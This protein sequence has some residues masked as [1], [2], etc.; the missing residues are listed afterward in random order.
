M[1]PVESIHTL[2]DH[3]LFLMAQLA[4]AKSLAEAY[5]QASIALDEQLERE[6]ANKTQLLATVAEL[7]RVVTKG[8]A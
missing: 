7:Q 8:H 6:R 1:T 4:E 2:C 5:R 3:C